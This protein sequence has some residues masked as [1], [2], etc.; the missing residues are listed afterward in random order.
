MKRR[1]VAGCGL[2]VALTAMVFAVTAAY[3]GS[4]GDLDRSFGHRGRVVLQETR[5]IARAVAVGGH[6]RIVA[7]GDNVVDD[8]SRHDK[9]TVARLRSGGHLDN[10]FG[11]H[12]LVTLRFDAFSAYA[13]SVAI[14]GKGAIVVAGTLCDGMGSPVACRF[15][16]ARLQRDGDID[17]DFGDGGTVEINFPQ[18]LAYAQSVALQRQGRIVVGGSDCDSRRSGCTVALAALRPDGTL[19]PGFG[20]GGKVV[21]SIRRSG[22]HCGHPGVD[23]NVRGIATDSR[24]RIVVLAECGGLLNG[25]GVLARFNP[26]GERDPSFGTGGIVDRDLGMQLAQALA[27]DP[28][29]RIDVAGVSGKQAGPRTVSVARLE[30]SGSS[31]RSFGKDGTAKITFKHEVD[32]Y[33]TAIDSRGRIVVGAESLDPDGSAFARFKHDGRVDRRFGRH[34]RVI[35]AKAKRRIIVPSGMAVDARDRIIASGTVFHFPRHFAFVR[36]LG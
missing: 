24:G 11:D 18:A 29:E 6:K 8:V 35:V 13:A 21:R 23:G 26:S 34:G 4:A 9:I 33:S 28:R 31:D 16:V 22:E 14:G 32:P 17:R 5:A 36:L 20:Q 30:R 15:V 19:D 2:V 3:A 12:G 27:I 1:L 10:R 25:K 7:V